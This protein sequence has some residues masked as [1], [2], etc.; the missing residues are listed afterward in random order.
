VGAGPYLDLEDIA[1]SL[2]PAA[3]LHLPAGTYTGN[4]GDKDTGDFQLIYVDGNFHQ[5]G[6]GQGAG[7]LIVDG[8][9]TLSGAFVW[10]GAVI[11]LGEVVIVGGGGTKH[12]YG[13]VFVGDDVTETGTTAE[14]GITGTSDLTYSS[15]SEEALK[16]MPTY[17]IQYW[18]QLH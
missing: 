6:S 11:V 5:S 18:R 4:W 17:L 9:M 2:E 16:T 14:F 1:T 12:V 3:D 8:T 7:I 15:Q 10:Y 13:A